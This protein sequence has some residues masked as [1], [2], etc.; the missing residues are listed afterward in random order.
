MLAKKAIL[1]GAILICSA[2]AS[3]SEIKPWVGATPPLRLRDLNDKPFDLAAQRGRV[4]LVNFW[5]SWC[6]PCREEMPALE[7]LRAKLRDRG[8]ELVTVNYGQSRDAASGFLARLN[9]ELP[10]LLD[11]DK[12]SAEAWRVRGLPMTILVDAQGKARYSSFGEQDWSEGEPFRL[13]EGLV[14]EA[15]R[16]KR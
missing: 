13:V 5:A 3:A 6:E 9:L 4:V 14:A 1:V 7:R 12:Q 10:V 8:F 11:V 16:A 2:A 15:Q